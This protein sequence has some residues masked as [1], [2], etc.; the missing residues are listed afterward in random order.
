[1]ART[2]TEIPAKA[3]ARWA[4]GDELAASKLAGLKPRQ[5]RNRLGP[6]G[7]PTPPAA[8]APAAPQKLVQVQRDLA[9]AAPESAPADPDADLDVAALDDPTV[10]DEDMLVMA[11]RLLAKVERR[12]KTADPV[13]FAALVEKA[14]G[15]IGRVH[16]LEGKRPKVS[17]EDLARQTLD[18]L[19]LET[20]AIIE[21]TTVAAEARAAKPRPGAPHGVCV[22][23]AH[24]LA[25]ALEAAP[26]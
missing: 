8:V 25:A 1:M 26:I 16:Q 21:D 19:D 18:T 2:P 24:P 5:L 6:P 7:R 3:V 22:T 23:C 14:N 20:L 4:V 9:A 12:I 15:L 10:P 13:R 11:R 17:A